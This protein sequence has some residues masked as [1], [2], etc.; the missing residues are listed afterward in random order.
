MEFHPV[1]KS[2]FIRMLNQQPL[3]PLFQAWWQGQQFSPYPSLLRA[4]HLTVRHAT[5]YVHVLYEAQLAVTAFSY[6]SF[7]LITSYLATFCKI[8]LWP[9]VLKML[10]F[11]FLVVIFILKP[12]KLCIYFEY[13]SWRYMFEEIFI[14]TVSCH[15]CQ[16]WKTWRHLEILWKLFSISSFAAIYQES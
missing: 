10:Q 6:F 5:Q 2:L 16:P 8:I 4:R 14:S 13:Y 1:A 11:A 7:M 12:N 15:C 9:L 3:W